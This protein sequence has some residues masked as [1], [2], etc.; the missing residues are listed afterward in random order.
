M[1]IL[2]AEV[3]RKV[4]TSRSTSSEMNS[5]KYLRTAGMTP[6]APF[7]G[8]VTT[9][10]PAALTSLTAMA[11]VNQAP[12]VSRCQSKK[13]PDSLAAQEVDAREDV[14]FPWDGTQLV[15]EIAND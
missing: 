5:T 1:S 13:L 2:P 12:E 11:L 8:A 4:L 14:G 9:L 6:A 3:S 15:L 7:V 10:P